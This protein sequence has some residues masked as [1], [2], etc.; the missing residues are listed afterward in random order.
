MTTNLLRVLKFG[1]QNFLRNS[2][3]SAVTILTLSMVLLV[4]IG[5]LMFMGVGRDLIAIF[6]DKI[7]IA[8]Y[9]KEATTE[10][11][12]LTIKG[13]LEDLNDIKKVDYISRDKALE[14]FSEKHSSDQTILQAL[15]ELDE[16]P[17]LAS[18][19]IKAEQ[20]DKYQVIAEYLT[21]NILQDKIEKVTYAQ[22]SLVIDKMI[23]IINTSQVFGLAVVIFLGLVAALVLINTIRLVIYSNRNEIE[24]ARL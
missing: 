23:K 19:N 24:I 14:I 20:P 3:V 6:Q 4:F 8:V 1:S 13:A 7:D 5:L 11:E 22:N 12:V 18:L 15:D 16:N 17:L 10:D 21:G 2:L 9:F